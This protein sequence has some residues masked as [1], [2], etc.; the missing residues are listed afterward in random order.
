MQPATAHSARCCS[1]TDAQ[2]KSG[3]RA[4]KARP[5]PG[6]ALDLMLPFSEAAGRNQS[7]IAGPLSRI[8]PGAARVL[9]IGSGTGQHAVYFSER[10]PGV[11]WQCTDLAENLPGLQARI[12]QEGRTR[13]P[14]ALELDVMS[15]GWPR[16]SFDA[17]FTANTL[18]IMPW[19]HTPVL[20]ARSATLLN[21]GG[22]L[23]IYGPFHDAGVHTAP[24]NEAFD[25]SLRARNPAMGVRDAVQ[26][27]ALANERGL[28]VEADLAL[29]ANNRILVFR[30]PAAAPT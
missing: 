20:L 13:L 27:Q 15:D 16:V 5:T 14:D 19:D 23:A 11:Y 10:F 30:K 9:E 28:Q 1:T 25:R 2:T 26:I 18:H 4:C 6:A 7:A 29:P 22:C 21:P 8:L 17:V 3:R 12:D 24:S